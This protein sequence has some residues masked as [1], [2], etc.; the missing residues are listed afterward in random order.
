MVQKVLVAFR[1]NSVY[2][3]LGYDILWLESPIGWVDEVAQTL[4]RDTALFGL[5]NPRRLWFGSSLA[6]IIRT[7]QG[8]SRSF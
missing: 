4:E 8:R 5:R 2:T 7:E 3:G 6:C 1:N